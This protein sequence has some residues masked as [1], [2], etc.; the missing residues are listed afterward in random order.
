[1]RRRAG[2]SL[3]DRLLFARRVRDA[4]AKRRR[5][6]KWRKLDETF[7]QYMNYGG[8]NVESKR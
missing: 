2:E 1:M 5:K 3:L 6:S 7:R 4:K 8:E